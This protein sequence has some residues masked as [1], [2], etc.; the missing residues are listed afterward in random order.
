MPDAA[1][2]IDQ[3]LVAFMSS[4]FSA[5]PLY[6]SLTP[7]RMATD[8][9][10]YAKQP[11]VQNEIAY[12]RAKVATIETPEA[13]IKDFRLLKFALSAYSMESQLQ[14]PARIKQILM[15]D[16][17]D[18]KALVNKM[19]DSSYRTLNQAFNFSAGGV[20]NL[21]N[22]AFI[23]SL[24]TRYTQANYEQSL[25]EMNPALTDALYFE[26]TIKNVKN[27]FQI[28]GDAVLFDVVK[29]ALNIPNAAA[30]G[31]VDRLKDW[32]ERDFD[33]S[34]VAD[35]AYINK[36]LKRYLVL[37][38]VEQRQESSDNPLLGILA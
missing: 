24:V 15:S 33:L 5:F 18:S 2:L 35:P 14:Y 26:R 8:K 11:N 38:D 21:K 34:K 22:K 16:P 3:G 13:F 37:K 4:I 31:S 12:F 30:T 25:G 7:E 20:E 1:P 23:D 19:N 6:Q 29:I 36:M 27:G 10:K 32:I 9:A 17:L 28:I